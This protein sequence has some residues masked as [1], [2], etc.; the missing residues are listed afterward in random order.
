MSDKMTVAQALRRIKKLKGL[1][2]ESGE[3]ARTGVSYDVSKLPAFRF[4]ESL[5]AM[6]KAQDEMIS[7]EARVAVANAT[8]MVQDGNETI[9]LALAIRTLQELKGR[10]AFL[11]VLN[12][13]NETV[14]DRQTEWDDAEG[15]H[16]YRTTETVF[17]SDLTE[18]SRDS[19]V[20]ALQDHF[21][22]LNNAVEDANHAVVV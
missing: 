2:A 16:I 18:Q 13:R 10:L 22:T 5:I 3:R 20:K 6:W 8:A 14:K 12:L 21:E 15:K 17:Q 11:K 1:I 7:L 4:Q 9:S 19:Q